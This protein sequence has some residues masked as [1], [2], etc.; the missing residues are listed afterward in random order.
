MRKRKLLL[1]SLMSLALVGCSRTTSSDPVSSE[2][3][4]SE[5]Q[6]S[7]SS[8]TKKEDS[9]SP[10]VSSSSDDPAVGGGESSSSSSTYEANYSSWSNDV[11]AAMKKYLGGNMVPFINVGAKKNQVASW[12]TSSN[13]D[14]GHLEVSGDKDLTANMVTT[15]TNDYAQAGYSITDNTS[16][17]FTAT[18]EDGL[19][20]VVLSQDSVGW[21]LLTI[22]YD[23]PYDN[24]KATAWDSD[25]QTLINDNL[26]GNSVPYIYLAT[27][28]VTSSFSDSTLTITGGKWDDRV[29]TDANTALAAA[30]GWVVSTD[31][32]STSLTATYTDTNNNELVID[33]SKSS[34]SNYSS[35]YIAKM[36]VKIKEAWNPSSATG[37]SWAQDI[38]TAFSTYTGNHVIPYLYT[39]TNSPSLSYTSSYLQEVDIVGGD[40]N[41]NFPNVVKTALEAENTS[42]GTPTSPETLWEIS[43]DDTSTSYGTKLT[44]SRYYSDGCKIKILARCNSSSKCALEIYYTEGWSPDP[45]ITDW[46]TSVKTDMATYLDNHIIPYFWIGS[47]APTS[48]GYFS[49]YYAYDY[50]YVTGGQW[51]NSVISAAETAFANDNSDGTWVKTY[52]TGYYGYSYYYYWTKTFSDGHEVKVRLED[53]SKNSYT[54]SISLYIEIKQVYDTKYNTLTDWTSSILS[55]FDTYYGYT[56]ADGNKKTNK[57]PYFYMGTNTKLTGT[58]SSSYDCYS[59]EGGAW[60][61]KVVDTCKSALSA[62]TKLEWSTSESTNTYG[63]TLKATSSL[64]EN[65]HYFVIELY[66]DY[67]EKIYL[68][69]YYYVGY[70]ETTF[71]GSWA[72][73]V[74]TSMSTNFGYSLPAF[75]IATT[76]ETVAYSSTYNQITIT[77]GTYDERVITNA[78]TA[79]TNDIGDSL[80]TAPA[81]GDTSTATWVITEGKYNSKKA[82]FAY[83][84]LSTGSYLRCRVAASSS[85]SNSKVLVNF[86]YDKKETTTETSWSTTISDDLTA[87]LG[88]D[89]SLPFFNFGLASGSVSL[90]SSTDYEGNKYLGLSSSSSFNNYYVFALKEALDAD[91]TWNVTFDPCS[92]SY[93]SS[94]KAY[95]VVGST[96]YS[97]NLTYTYASSSLYVATSPLYR[98]P[99]ENEDWTTDQKTIM[100]DY[101]GG[102]V[103]PYIYL[104]DNVSITTGDALTI[105]GNAYS[106]D[107]ISSVESIFKTAGYSIITYHLQDHNVIY[108]SKE[109]VDETTGDTH[110]ISLS[111]YDYGYSRTYGT[112]N[113]YLTCYYL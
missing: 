68:D 65:N 4:V 7:T 17:G 55:D 71:A 30:T 31:S 110:Y 82:L 35:L 84:K 61:N 97:I 26:S 59:I 14:Y 34:K 22:T 103:L 104:G 78:K 90:T 21:A 69:I 24:T 57:V 89:V 6:S 75:Y 10:L 70:D 88:S 63:K 77:G 54:Y 27:A 99:N 18:S 64:T 23:E 66:T 9:S 3:P 40:Y 76:D 106:S 15:A 111:F 48:Y 60:D 109:I 42:I 43:I 51:N 20:K 67:Y 73:D 28:N 58:Y 85:T 44:A 81:G 32:T 93:G 38:L 80:S 102:E 47:S 33:I 25:T 39:G 74:A 107:M 112:H 86:Y 79:L 72:S 5:K 92:T 16:S 50:M 62:D 100:E 13:S 96:Y 95:K 45:T 46:P 41:T 29:I 91:A 19:I 101:L 8:S 105:Q 36:T 1:I 87:Y 2:A 108:G 52:E 56:D 83:K 53:Q 11:Q 94:L 113:P 49:S 12:D 98:E 37:V